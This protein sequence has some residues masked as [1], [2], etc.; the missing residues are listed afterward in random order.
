VD[1]WEN[2][3]S[4]GLWERKGALAVKTASRETLFLLYDVG[5]F[6]SNNNVK[7]PVNHA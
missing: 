3:E 4:E 2:R 5:L 7:I 1:G 6:F